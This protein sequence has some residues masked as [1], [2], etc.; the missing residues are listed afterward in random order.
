MSVQASTLQNQ[1]E[2]AERRAERRCPEHDATDENW[3]I[4]DELINQQT[5]V[6]QMMSE[7]NMKLMMPE[8]NPWTAT[9]FNDL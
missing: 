6:N 3:K 2:Q 1:I 8:G 5:K 9:E 4:V 7:H